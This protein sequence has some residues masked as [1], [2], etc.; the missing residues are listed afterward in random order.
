[1]Q[2][3]NKFF[4]L[5]PL[6][7]CFFSCDASANNQLLET[8]HFTI[9]IDQKGQV[10]AL[11]EKESGKNLLLPGYTVPLLTIESEGNQYLVTSWKSSGD[12]LTLNFDKTRAGVDIK[13]NNK[14]EYLTFEIVRIDSEKPIDKV[15]WGPFD[16]LPSEK[17]GQSI[18][19]AY[20]DKVAIGFMGLNLKSRGGFEQLERGR[21]GNTAQKIKGGTS[22]TGFVR[23]RST[24]RTVDNWEQKLGQ[25]VPLNDADAKIVGAKFAMYCIP[26]ENLT[27]VIER[28]VLA[29][30]LPHIKNEGTWNKISNYSTSSKFIM[31]YNVKNIDDC[32]DIAKKAGI[33]CVYHGGIFKT[34]GTF[35]LSENDFP[36]GYQSVRECSDKAEKQGLILALIL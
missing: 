19:I 32:I 18:G 34:W 12:I 35:K 13:I 21:F 23:N 26:A 33:T 36:N 22:L 2:V 24:F 29:E 17:I 10:T 28:I 11:I 9:S 1:M 8:D 30:N 20:N 4:L 6:V 14:S 5:I 25:A 31:S 7:Y 15:T 16:V 3:M 27:K